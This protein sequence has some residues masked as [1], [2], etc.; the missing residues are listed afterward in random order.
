MLLYAE[1]GMVDACRREYEALLPVTCASTARDA[2]ALC[3]LL[4]TAEACVA[5]DDAH[6]AAALRE[7]LQPHAGSALVIDTGGGPCAGSAD[8]LRGMLATVCGDFDAAQACFDA[9]LAFETS[10][11]WR[12]W[13]AHTRFRLAWMWQRRNAPGDAEAAHHLATRVQTE[14]AAIGLEGVRARCQSLLTRLDT[15]RPR[16]PVGL[17]DR[18]VEVL[19]LIAIGRNNREVG[20]VLSISPNTVANHM[21]SILDKT[22]CANR[23]EAAAFAAR[24]G[25]LKG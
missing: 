25:L 11:G 1:L 13:E 4:F 2:H 14:A 10:C 3:R 8:R 21:R 12:T 23:T 17:T 16:H 22:Y 5:L 15:T 6:G 19:Q 9:A 24:E 18:E 7:R 20:Q